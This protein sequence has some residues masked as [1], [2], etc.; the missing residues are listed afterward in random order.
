MD[1][2]SLLELPEDADERSIKRSYAR[3]LKI[4]RPD[5]DAEGFQRLREA[6]ERALQLA[7]WREEIADE[8]AVIQ[9][10]STKAPPPDN[11]QAWSGLIEMDAAA[12]RPTPRGPSQA[13][14]WASLLEDVPLSVEPLADWVPPAPQDPA[15]LPAPATSALPLLKGLSVENLPERWQQ[16]R[17]E[18]CENDFLQ[19]LLVACCAHPE[20]YAA[21]I[22]W[23]AEH[24]DWLTPWQQPPMEAW[25]EAFLV[26]TLLQEYRRTLEALLQAGQERAFLERLTSYCAQPWLRIFDHRQN[27][28]HEM[29]QLLQQQAWQVPLFDR[30]CQLFGWDESRGNTPEPAWL[31]QSLI[32]RCQQEAFYQELLAKAGEPGEATPDVAAAR[33]LLNP[34]PR[35]RQVALTRHFED[36]HWQ[37]CMELSQT[38]ASRFPALLERMPR[39]DVFFWQNLMPRPQGVDSWIRSGVAMGLALSLYFMNKAQHSKELAVMMGL[40]CGGVLAI[41][42]LILLNTWAPAIARLLAIDLWLSERLVPKRLNPHQHW[43]V[44]RHGVPQAVMLG[45]FGYWLGALGILAYLGFVLIGLLHSRRIGQPDPDF[46]ARSPWLGA[47]HWNHFSP[48]QPIYLVVMIVVIRVC[49]L[50]APG[51]PWTRL[52]P[53]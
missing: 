8:V 24:L 5:E 10:A 42:G 2:W 51:F 14:Q 49:Q 19:R 11:L 45:L 27:W 48:W 18:G 40:F 15:P 39:S 29:L 20:Q 47:L 30:V 7:R 36:E 28:Q 13:Q 22:G 44:L 46:C 52:M 53:G 21:I 4:T 31:W 43:L 26:K 37:A 41:F 16:A 12:P 6:Y 1:C 50:H 3:Q 9:T 34:M 23:A 38:L 25:Q 35:R 33:L 17:Q 32:E